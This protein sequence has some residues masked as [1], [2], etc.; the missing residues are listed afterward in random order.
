MESIP[1]ITDEVLESPD[2]MVD[3][4]AKLFILAD[5]RQRGQIRLQ[6]FL[7]FQQMS[8]TAF[9]FYSLSIKNGKILTKTQRQEAIGVI[10]QDWNGLKWIEEDCQTFE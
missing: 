8:K 2:L 4:L 9:G 6:D 1:V 10:S 5:K 3:V 7:K